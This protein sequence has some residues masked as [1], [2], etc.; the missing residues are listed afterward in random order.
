MLALGDEGIVLSENC[1]ASAG[2]LVAAADSL[3][4]K[5]PSAWAD[6]V[7]DL[8]DR[9]VKS[10]RFAWK[11][12]MFWVDYWLKHEPVKK[13]LAKR[14]PATFQEL[15]KPC[16]LS[17]TVDGKGATCVIRGGDL[18]KA[19]LASMSIA[20]VWPAVQWSDELLLSDGGTTHYLPI[21]PDW[22]EFDEIYLMIALPALDYQGRKGGIPTR[23][24]RN[25]DYLLQD[26]I[27][28]VLR[29]IANYDMRNPLYR[30]GAR[31]KVYVLRPT[32]NQDKGVLHFDHGLID[33]ARVQA[34]AQLRE[35]RGLPKLKESGT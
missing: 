22:K 3:G 4:Q 10:S 8:K 20:G 26:Q 2:A 18:Q 16:R 34:R 15:A 14:L 25:I 1:G 7:R 29:A 24:M 31:P 30:S 11:L 6:I 5:L 27:N 35:Q 33:Q 17:C 23:F 12:R 9:D 28:D 13:L 32:C 21:P 19:V